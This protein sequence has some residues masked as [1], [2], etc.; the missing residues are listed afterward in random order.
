MAGFVEVA[1]AEEVPSGA[2][3][4]VELE[5]HQIALVNVDGT[6]Y[7]VDNECPHRGGWLGEGELTPTGATGPWSVPC[8][9]VS[10][11]SAPARSST[12]RLPTASAAIGSK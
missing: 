6:F 12:L 5:G 1:R 3:R 9:A 2:V 4:L 7:A 8:T 11:M 10:S